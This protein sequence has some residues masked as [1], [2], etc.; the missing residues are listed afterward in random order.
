MSCAVQTPPS[1]MAA[2][3]ESKRWPHHTYDLWL[4]KNSVGPRMVTWRASVSRFW[5]HGPARTLWQL[6]TWTPAGMP[7]ETDACTGSHHHT[8]SQIRRLVREMHLCWAKASKARNYNW[9]KQS[10]QN[11]TEHAGQDQSTNCCSCS[12]ARFSQ[13]Q[14]DLYFVSQNKLLD[15]AKSCLLIDHWPQIRSMQCFRESVQVFPGNFC[16]R[17]RCLGNTEP[18]PTMRW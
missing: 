12:L 7:H 11:Q 15:R 18:V 14:R 9:P 2:S 3:K 1:A 5:Y 16:T 10:W 8:N 4:A 6:D 17:C 13:W